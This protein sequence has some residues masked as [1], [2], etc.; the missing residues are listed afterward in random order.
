M[1]RF[2]YFIALTAPLILFSCDDDKEM[3]LNPNTDLSFSGTFRTFN[4]ASVSGTATLQISNGYYTATTSLPFGVGA[5]K[6]EENVLRLNFVDTLFFPIPA[7]YGP[8]FVLSGEHGYSFDGDN[9]K[10]RRALNVGYVE[11]NL[12]RVK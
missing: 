7:L 3:Q 2:A 6:L 12:E 4:E 8:S 5:G 10:I 11:Y 9:L 1:K